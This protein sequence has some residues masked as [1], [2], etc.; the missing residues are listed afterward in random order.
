MPDDQNI[1]KNQDSEENSIPPSTQQ[2]TEQV[3][4]DT[5]VSEHPNMSLRRSV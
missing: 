2:P 3:P 1:T 4:K 5:T